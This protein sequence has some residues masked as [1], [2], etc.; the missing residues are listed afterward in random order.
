MLILFRDF[1]P[2]VLPDVTKNESKESFAADL[3]IRDHLG[4]SFLKQY[5]NIVV[6]VKY[7]VCVYIYSYMFNS[8][9][10]IKHNTAFFKVRIW[11]GHKGL[12]THRI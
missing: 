10:A 11:R 12:L 1:I 5:L 4:M 2:E 6:C 7:Y 8:L 9:C 3:I